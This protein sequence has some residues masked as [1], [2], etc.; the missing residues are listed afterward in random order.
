MPRCPCILVASSLV[1]TIAI[2]LT[3]LGA[4]VPVLAADS[5]PIVALSQER[6]V[7]CSVIADDSTSSD[8]DGDFDEA[9]GFERFRRSVGATALLDSGFA[10][11]GAFQDSVIAGE[12]IVAS[13]NASGFIWLNAPGSAASWDARSKLT[14]AFELLRQAD[15][16]LDGTLDIPEVGHVNLVLEGPGGPLHEFFVFGGQTIVDES[17]TLAAGPYTLHVLADASSGGW[18]PIQFETFASYDVTLDF[19]SG[20]LT[21]PG[22]EVPDGDDVPAEHPLSVAKASGGAVQLAWEP[23]CRHGDDDYGVYEAPLGEPLGFVAV[24]CSTGRQT[25]HEFAPGFESVM[26]VVV[27]ND[28]VTEGSYG[29]TSAGIERTPPPAACWPQALGDP[30]CP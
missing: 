20:G 5:L 10:S 4:L 7:S 27:P 28:G 15:Y 30:V 16:T 19:G 22:G 17:G 8:S 11:T 24:T 21:D 6:F 12:G 29:D 18:G 25:E 2:G 26:F 1:P 23:S 13:G 9:E 3:G 14:V